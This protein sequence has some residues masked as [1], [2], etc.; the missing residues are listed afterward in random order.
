MLR[1]KRGMEMAITTVIMI[2]LSIS[3]LTVLVI[4]FNSQSGFLSRVLKSS[5]SESNVDLILNTCLLLSE[6][7]SSYSYCCDR[8]EVIINSKT[9]EVM[10]C[11]DMEGK[12]WS[13]N[14]LGEYDCTNIV[15]EVLR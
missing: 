15:C 7:E 3:I 6:T 13:G 1:E 14:K 11:K 8:R 10:A 5:A 12:T 2:I 9:K 4:F